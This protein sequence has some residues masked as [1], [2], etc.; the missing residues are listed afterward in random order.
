MAEENILS[1][2]D[3]NNM[4]AHQQNQ[5]RAKR[6][7]VAEDTLI[8]AHQQAMERQQSIS[9]EQLASHLANTARYTEQQQRA[10]AE[11]QAQRSLQLSAMQHM[12][13]QVRAS[14]MHI[15]GGPLDGKTLRVTPPQPQ[16]SY[17]QRLTSTQPKQSTAQRSHRAPPSA[18]T[19]VRTST[20]VQQT[21]AKRRQEKE[22]AAKAAAAANTSHGRTYSRL[23]G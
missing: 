10:A 9:N 1:T 2:A 21:E 17:D 12:A 22:L 14:Q 11:L 8:P 3:I 7:R 19:A 18:T 13:H 23:P 5:Q 15:Q 4:S 6:R 16:S 20:R